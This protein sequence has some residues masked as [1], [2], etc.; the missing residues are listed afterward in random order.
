[1]KTRDEI[2][3][4]IYQRIKVSVFRKDKNSFD[5]LCELL[6]DCFDTEEQFAM[7]I[8]STDWNEFNK[9]HKI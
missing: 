5:S 6:R 4:R 9:V 3:R 2:V 7:Y 8:N 1:M